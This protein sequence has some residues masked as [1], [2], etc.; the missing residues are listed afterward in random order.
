MNNLSQ[1]IIEKFKLTK[2]TRSLKVNSP[3]IPGTKVF[4]ISVYLE[5]THYRLATSSNIYTVENFKNDILIINSLPKSHEVNLNSNLYYEEHKEW[6]N[7]VKNNI[8]TIVLLIEDAIEF[9][10]N[11]KRTPK[12]HVDKS[13]LEKYFDKGDVF[14]DK[15]INICCYYKQDVINHILTQLKDERDN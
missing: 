12:N 1:Y 11:F 8:Y 15:K 5:S 4:L 14:F 9:W 6:S 2:N 10:E 3:T 7:P 13:C